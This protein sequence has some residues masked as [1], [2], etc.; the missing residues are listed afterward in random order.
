MFS[1]GSEKEAKSLLVMSC[2]TNNDGEYIARQLIHDQSLD[3]LQ[4][5]SD[6][7]AERH[8]ILVKNGSCDCNGTIQ[9]QVYRCWHCEREVDKEYFCYGCKKYIC[10][11]CEEWESVATR[12]MG[13][14]D[15]MDHLTKF[16]EEYL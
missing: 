13:P 6:F 5:F 3:N 9:R 4:E 8:E 12:T 10:D 14:H 2:P 7:L 11:D 1:V 15:P 16:E